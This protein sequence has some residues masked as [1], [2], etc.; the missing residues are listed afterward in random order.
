MRF[1]DLFIKGSHEICQ[2]VPEPTMLTVI[3]VSILSL[4]IFWFVIYYIPIKCYR[5]PY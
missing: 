5:D 4:L 3:L 1:K 2:Q